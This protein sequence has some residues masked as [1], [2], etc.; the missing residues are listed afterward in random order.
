VTAPLAVEPVARCSTQRARVVAAITVLVGAAL[1]A[2]ALRL[3][4]GSTEFYAVTL[5]V[6][7]TWTV[8][9]V[10]VRP[11]PIGGRRLRDDATVGA[12]LGAVMF[13]VFVA[14][15]AIG[16]HIDAIADAID[17]ILRKA[18][19]GPVVAVLVV[20]LLNGVAEELFFRNTLIVA[21][22]T[23]R[24]RAYVIAFVVYVVVTAVSANTALTLAAVVMGAVFAV[25]RW[26]TGN[27]V[28]PI[29]THVVWS[30]LM[31][32]AFPR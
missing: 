17:R 4:R 24:R 14:G 22:G 2:L 23:Q 16:R 15:A 7:L 27:L 13:G 8:P 6:A 21:L 3:R 19:G 28:A 25:E 29:A 20:A 1:L 10:L 31:I 9:S 18:D 32:L 11:P 30:T 5:L 12:L 26:R